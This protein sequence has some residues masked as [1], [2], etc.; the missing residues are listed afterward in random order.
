MSRNP[1]AFAAPFM[2]VVELKRNCPSSSSRLS[3]RLKSTRFVA[4]TP[5]R[6]L[7][8]QLAPAFKTIAGFRKDNGKSIRS[9][10]RGHAQSRPILAG[11]K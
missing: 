3:H 1:P 2:T 5:V 11:Q 8:G 9:H 4:S 10:A 7:T 6:W